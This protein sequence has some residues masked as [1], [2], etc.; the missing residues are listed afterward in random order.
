MEPLS[1]NIYQNINKIISHLPNSATL[2]KREILINKKT[3]CFIIYVSNLCNRKSIEMHIIHPLLYKINEDIENIENAAEYIAQNY[4]SI[5]EAQII[6]SFDNITVELLRGKCLI[7][8]D[9]INTA[10]LCDTSDIPHRQ[11]QE[12][13][14]E[15]T[16]RGG[17]ESFVENIEINLALIQN[18][19]KSNKLRIE[20]ML[21]GNENKTDAAIV[22]MDG[23]I[24]PIVLDTIKFKMNRIKNLPYILCTGYIEQLIED[25]PYGFFP[26][27]KN[28]EKPDK[29]VSDLFQ[30]KAAILISGA[31]YALI[32]PAVFIEFFQ[33]FED[34]SQ[35]LLTSVF[36]RITRVLSA[37]LVLLATPIYLTVLS[38]S[39]GLV[40]I[41]LIKVIYNSRLGIPLPP[42]LEILTMEIAVE[43]LREGGLRLPSPIGQT[44]G[45]VGGIVIGEAATK[46]GLVSP[47]TLVVVS[48]TV[49][50]SFLIPNYEMALSIRFLRFPM[51]ILAELFG[52]LGIILGFYL[53]VIILI[54]MNSFGIPYFSPFAPLNPS[55]LKDTI[56]RLSLKEILRKPKS[57][58]MKKGKI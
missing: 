31:P 20:R 14:V 21:L 48:T 19:V 9:K 54:N 15:K 44:L 40:P 57:L 30:G 28:T 56:V 10:I 39:S 29:V 8:I 18:K 34:Y 35:R 51:L 6:K 32:A 25:F 27:L 43:L 47:T 58:K 16:I 41:K 55:D 53:I 5:S 17:R 1:K 42:F 38:Y 36:V 12:S 13:N 24:D 11:I 26:Q 3:K 7:L 52:F 23:I 37:L 33:G 22:Y 46:A 4:I 45:I 49:I 2:I 50:A